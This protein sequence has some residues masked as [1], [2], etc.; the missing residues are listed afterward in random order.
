MKKTRVL[1]ILVFGVL[2]CAAQSA[3]AEPMGTA[4]T[5]Q[6]QLYD[7]SYPANGNYDFAFKLYDANNDGNKVGTDV[8]VADVNVID[9]YFTVKLDFGSGVFDGNAHWL[10]IGIRQGVFN[11]PCGYTSLS[12]R[13]E[14]TPTPYALYAKSGTPGPQGPKGDKG[15]TGDTGPV[16]PPGPQGEQGSQ[17]PQGE[18]G[19][20]G[21]Q[22]S[23][24]PQGETGP[25]G[26]QGP[27]GPQG[28]PGDSHWQI[29][30]SNTY[31]NNGNV[32]I[33]T[34]NPQ[35]TLHV[36]GVVTAEKFIG[37]G[38]LV[39]QEVTGTSQQA[40]PNTGYIAN[41][42]A[43]VTITLPPSP[44]IGDIVRVSYG[45]VGNLKVAQNEG[46]YIIAGNIVGMGTGIGGFVWTPRGESGWYWRAVASSADGRKLVAVAYSGRIYTSTDSGVSWTARGSSRAWVA[47]ASSADG[48]KLVAVVGSPASG[49]IYTSVDSGVNWTSRESSRYWSGVAS[50]ADG[51]KLVAVVHG[52]QI[53]TST[54]SG[55]S[56]T[57]RESSRYWYGVASSADGSKLVAVGYNSQIYTSTDYGVSWTARE[58]SRNWGAV[59]SSADGSKLVAASSLIYTSTDSGVSWTARASSNN[60]NGIASSADGSKLVAAANS[61]AIYTSSDYGVSWAPRES[62]REWYGVAS[63]ADGSK[64]V[65]VASGGNIYTSIATTTPGTSG[66]LVGEQGAAIE[67]Q[68]A[69]NGKWIL[70]SHED[71]ISTY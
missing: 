37:F 45:G 31:Y 28:P 8:N 60:W 70:L 22:G 6:G 36:A 40:I 51:S 1:T 25:Q 65:A 17:G 24:G 49:Q 62:N 39:W 21:E 61:R 32:G 48:S 58:S 57:P 7:A 35:S 64:M 23:Q 38:A 20:Q 63:S 4:F 15:D 13:Q 55:V 66:Y 30:D 68:Y 53:Y 9:G 69:G 42:A 3:N 14:V 19:P 67:L 71:P 5:Y 27:E 10:E 59:A 2:V 43:Q 34:N 46:Q 33:G 52:G 26:E 56:W 16:G 41:N 50:S 12:P 18:T 44:E 54:D 29:S 11:D 47:V